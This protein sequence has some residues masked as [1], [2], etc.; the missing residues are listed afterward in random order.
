MSCDEHTYPAIRCIRALNGA[1]KGLLSAIWAAIKIYNL[2]QY[3]RI[4]AGENKR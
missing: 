2:E 4:R 3:D 1:L